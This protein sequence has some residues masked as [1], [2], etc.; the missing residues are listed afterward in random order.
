MKLILKVLIMQIYM[1]AKY[2]VFSYSDG[3]FIFTYLNRKDWNTNQEINWSYVGIINS[4][5]VACL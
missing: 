1:K 2:A 3:Y 4:V 5:P